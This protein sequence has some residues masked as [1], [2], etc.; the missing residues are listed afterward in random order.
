MDL[1]DAL[2]YCA[3]ASS[4]DDEG[5]ITFVPDCGGA[6]DAG[7]WLGTSCWPILRR[8]L[9]WCQCYKKLFFFVRIIKLEQQLSLAS[10][11]QPGIIF[12]SK[13]L[14]T[15]VRL[16]FKLLAKNKH[17]RLLVQNI[18]YEEKNVCQHCHLISSYLSIEA[19]DE[20][21]RNQEEK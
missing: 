9:S 16:D 6:T 5:L 3:Q 15:N 12:A 21:H 13:A 4:D 1:I 17:S 8:S 14:P 20:L 7:R 18:N 19:V 2:A 11:F 10:L